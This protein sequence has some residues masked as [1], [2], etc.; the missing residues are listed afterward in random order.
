M[1]KNACIL[2]SM[3]S[4]AIQ[5]AIAEALTTCT[6]RSCIINSTKNITLAQ[7]ITLANNNDLDFPIQFLIALKR[8]CTSHELL[9]DV[10]VYMDQDSVQQKL[11][12][13]ATAMQSRQYGGALKRIGAKKVNTPF[14]QR[15]VFVGPRGGEYVKLNN[16]VVRVNDIPKKK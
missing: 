6:S 5:G 13:I 14:G 4:V 8:I 1:S 9:T 11:N 3:N 16:K 12:A 10:D 7:I 15:T 2:S